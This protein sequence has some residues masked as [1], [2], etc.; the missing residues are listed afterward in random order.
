MVTIHEIRQWQEDMHWIFL[1]LGYQFQQSGFDCISNLPEEIAQR[2]LAGYR[3][4]EFI[5][6]DFEQLIH[7]CLTRPL[8]DEFSTI[9][10][11]PVTL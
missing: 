3:S 2:C 5:R 8:D 1:I 9:K 6:V 10:L 4:G 11:D 7:R